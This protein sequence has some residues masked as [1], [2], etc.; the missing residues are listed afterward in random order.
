MVPVASKRLAFWSIWALH[1]GLCVTAHRKARRSTRL[2]IPARSWT[3]E[4][5]GTNGANG[6]A[7]TSSEP[8]CWPRS[9]LNPTRS[10]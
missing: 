9:K 8:H 4:S 3:Q 2:R 5:P 1:L 6:R 10:N 7:T